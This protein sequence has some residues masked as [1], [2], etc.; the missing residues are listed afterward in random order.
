[1]KALNKRGPRINPCGTPFWI[2]AQ[3]L[4]TL[5][6]LLVYHMDH[7]TDLDDVI[8]GKHCV[9]VS[10]EYHTHENSTTTQSP[11][12]GKKNSISLVV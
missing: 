11:A 8:R 2:P 6:T 12:S 7:F 9:E 4:R 1:M 3:L 10:K 5:F